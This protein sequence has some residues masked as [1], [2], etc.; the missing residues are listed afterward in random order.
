M[1]PHRVRR[2]A[3]SLK[4]DICTA[5]ANR[6]VDSPISMT[7]PRTTL[8]RGHFAPLPYRSSAAPRSHSDTTKARSVSSARFSA[9]GRLL[10]S[11]LVWKRLPPGPRNHPSST[12]SAT[13]ASASDEIKQRCRRDTSK[14]LTHSWSARPN[15]IE[16]VDTMPRPA[17]SHRH[18]ATK[19]T[20]SAKRTVGLTDSGFT[21]ERTLH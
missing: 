13:Y 16:L 17:E 6:H 1:E 9:V 3:H 4:R 20:N 10:R 21:Q 2:L 18:G 11:Y 19:Q 7:L 14:S 12:S 8:I 15:A 5:A